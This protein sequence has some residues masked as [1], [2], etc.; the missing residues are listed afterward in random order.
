MRVPQSIDVLNGI[1]P[2]FGTAVARKIAFGDDPRHCLDV[3]RPARPAASAASSPLPTVLFF[4]GGSW[5]TGDRH[6]YAFLGRALARLGLVVAVADYRLYPDVHYPDF[7]HDAAKATAFMLRNAD[8]F[9]G[10]PQAVF[11]AGHSAGAYLAMMVALASDYLAA[12]GASRTDLAGAIGLAGP[13]DFLPITGPV[14]RR[15]FGPWADEVQTQPIA[16]VDD[17]APP[18][19]LLTGARDNLVAPSNTA[20]LAARLRAAGADVE[21]RIYPGIGHIRLLLAVLPSLGLLPPVWRHMADFITRTL[22]A[23][24]EA[25]RD[26][27]SADMAGRSHPG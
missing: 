9:G 22:A 26:N 25:P 13:Y 24:R 6:E 2:R 8:A 23:G 3:Y 18:C 4:Y 20:S 11:V 21:T 5:Q 12:A 10:D 14:Y 7:I 17:E 16:H 15:I 1:T 19:L 27:R